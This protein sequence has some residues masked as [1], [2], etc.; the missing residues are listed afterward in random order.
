MPYTEFEE[1]RPDTYIDITAVFDQKLRA[2]QALESQPFLANWYTGY[3]LQRAHQARTFSGNQ[4]IRYAEAFARYRP[5]VPE[6]LP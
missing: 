1:F 2:M 5:M 3:A 4:N 6:F